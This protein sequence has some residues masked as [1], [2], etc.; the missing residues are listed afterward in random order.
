[1]RIRMVVHR[2]SFSRSPDKD[3]LHR[4]VN[5]QGTW[6]GTAPREKGEKYETAFATIIADQIACIACRVV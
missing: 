3:Q 2:T 5:D 1:M 6:S 4:L